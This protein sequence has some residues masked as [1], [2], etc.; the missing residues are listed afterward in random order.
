MT[1]RLIAGF[2]AVNTQ[3]RVRS[4]GIVEIL[5]DQER[6]DGRV[7][8]LLAA[9]E[10]VGVRVTPT[11]RSRLDGLVPGGK[12]Q[13]VIARIIAQTQAR[14]LD[15]LLDL[16]AEP[17]LLLL[18]DGVTDPHN[19]GACLRVADAAGVHAVIAP[20]DKAVGLSTTVSRVAAG[21]AEIVPYFMVTNLARTMNELQER[22]IWL[23]GADDGA[24][25]DIFETDLKG[26]MGWVMGAEG[27]GLRRL[28]CERCDSLVRIPM[29]GSVAS[30]N[31]SV[32]SAV[33]LYETRRQRRSKTP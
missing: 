28:T 33:C 4:Q 24:S 14:S 25:R 19:L 6:H 21:A 12:H 22:G 23:I 17:P 11:T 3:I 27:A 15:D 30:L 8:A 32:A 1:Q 9:A 10:S 26:A 5:V 16:I 18:L 20:K 13:G 29:L 7:R 2:H 31:V